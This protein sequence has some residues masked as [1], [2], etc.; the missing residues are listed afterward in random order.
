MPKH[1]SYPIEFKRQVA[2]EYLAGETFHGLAKRHA[3][4][5]NLVRIWVAKHEGAGPGAI[6]QHLDTF[7]PEEHSGVSRVCFW[8]LR[9]SSSMIRTGTPSSSRAIPASWVSLTIPRIFTQA[10]RFADTACRHRQK[11]LLRNL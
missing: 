3:I 5:R 10:L 11:R 2:Q 1:R 7:H 6:E 4:S 8:R 9:R